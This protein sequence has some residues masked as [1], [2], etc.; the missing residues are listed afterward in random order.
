MVGVATTIQIKRDRDTWEIKAAR[1]SRWERK[2]Q[3]TVLVM[4][5]IGV[6]LQQRVS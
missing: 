3:S 5:S 1:D 6:A 4:E 2:H